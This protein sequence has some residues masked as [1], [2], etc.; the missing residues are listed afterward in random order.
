[1]IFIVNNFLVLKLPVNTKA[2]IHRSLFIR[3]KHKRTNC[4]YPALARIRLGYPN[5]N[6]TLGIYIVIYY[7]IFTLYT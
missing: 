1:M 7:N 3:E 4:H 5:T 6:S 2:F